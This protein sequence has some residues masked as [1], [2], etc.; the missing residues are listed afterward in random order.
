MD[1]RRSP[2]QLHFSSARLFYACIHDQG[3]GGNSMAHLM[4]T[5]SV[6]DFGSTNSSERRP[7]RFFRE[8]C[9][10]IA[11]DARASS[12]SPTDRKGFYRYEFNFRTNSQPNHSTSRAVTCRRSR[13]HSAQ[14]VLR[15]GGARSSAVPC[16]ARLPVIQ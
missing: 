14:R 9:P 7:A 15:G 16:P 11:R 8:F 6:L 4:A 3:G 2:F 1:I 12:S 13:L 5:Q 10:P